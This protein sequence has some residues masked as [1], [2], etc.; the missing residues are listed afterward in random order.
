MDLETEILIKAGA[1]LDTAQEITGTVLRMREF[2]PEALN[3][4][5]TEE[6]YSLVVTQEKEACEIVEALQIHVAGMNKRNAVRRV[7]LAVGGAAMI[8]SNAAVD[9]GIIGLSFG[10]FPIPIVTA[11]SGAAGSSLLGLGPLKELLPN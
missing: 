10:L 8:A 1:R 3:Y 11:I 2:S 9:A 6:V 7:G 4:R 5:S